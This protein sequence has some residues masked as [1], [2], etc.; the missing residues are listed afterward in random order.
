MAND[1]DA[2][3]RD[4]PTWFH[5]PWQHYGPTGREGVHG[6]TKEAP[7]EP[8]QLAISQTFTDGQ[9]YAVGLY[10]PFGGYTIGKVWA[11]KQ[12]P[13]ASDIRFPVGTVVIKVLFT[14]V[15]TDQVPSLANPLMWKAYVTLNYAERKSGTSRT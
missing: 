12:H 10:N 9:V 2:A 7:V 11:D 3:R 8:Q 4:K 5:V 14:D 1:F 13:D 15:P 6:L